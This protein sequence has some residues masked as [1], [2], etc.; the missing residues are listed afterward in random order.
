M[1]EVGI[2]IIGT[3]DADANHQILPVPTTVHF[4][5][6]RVASVPQYG[7]GSR[8]VGQLVCLVGQGEGIQRDIDVWTL[9]RGG[10]REMMQAV[11]C[12]ISSSLFVLYF[13]PTVINV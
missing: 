10:E 4:S 5:V 2:I 1:P 3:V 9:Q 7:Q 6:Q 12:R 11:S 13:V 8:A